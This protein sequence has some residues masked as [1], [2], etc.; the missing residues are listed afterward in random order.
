[1]SNYGGF[2]LGK[3][4][5]GATQYN[6]TVILTTGGVVFPALPVAARP[7]CYRIGR[8]NGNAGPVSAG[9]RAYSL[10]G[11]ISLTH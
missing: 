7:Y 3:I 8:S 4:F 1:V 5:I 2:T 10:T 9:G 6:T 11:A